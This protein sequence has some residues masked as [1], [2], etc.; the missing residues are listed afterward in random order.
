LTELGLTYA[1]PPRDLGGVAIGPA[2]PH[3]IGDKLD[4][5]PPAE[6]CARTSV[7]RVVGST[8]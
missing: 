8:P 1:A 2:Q 4:D 5:L 3:R 7:M 6:T